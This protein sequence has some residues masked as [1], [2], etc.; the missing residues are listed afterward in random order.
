MM[1]ISPKVSLFARRLA[2]RVAWTAAEAAV[3]YAAIEVTQLPEVYVVP[4]SALLAW[5]KGMIAK[6][7]GDPESPAIGAK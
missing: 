1:K 3:A 5:V 7:V 2:E 4:A 6:H